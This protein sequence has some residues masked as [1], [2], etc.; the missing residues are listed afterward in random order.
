MLLVRSFSLLLTATTFASPLAK[1]AAPSFA[2]TGD[3]PFSVATEELARSLTCPNGFPTTS[4]PPVLLVHGTATTGEE[5]W[6]KGYVPAL[7]SNKYTACYVTIP[8]RSMGDMQ[9]NAEYVAYSLHY[10]SSLS[11]GLKPAVIAHS[12]GAPNTQWALQFWPSTRNVTRAFIALAPDF[13]GIELFGSRSLFKG[14]CNSGLC[15]AALWQQNAGSNYYKALHSQDFRA[16]VPT[17]SI[18]SQFDAVVDPYEK[19]AQLPGAT[20]VSVQDLCPFRPTLHFTMTISAAV[21]ELTLNALNNNG[22][23]NLA[24]ANRLQCLR[25]TAKGMD[26]GISRSIE[27]YTKELIGGFLLATPLLRSEPATADYVQ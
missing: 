24:R 8:N 9:V 3:A 12:Q 16:L 2:F 13:D 20:V 11:G 25:T 26:E 23:V 17:S 21:F 6:G 1:R 7:K 22:A 19:N 14:I 18:W 27:S 4:S 5:S 10:L 15:Q